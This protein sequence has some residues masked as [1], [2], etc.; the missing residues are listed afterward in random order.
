MRA[1]VFPG[2]E[3]GKR[4]GL[5]PDIAFRTVAEDAEQQLVSGTAG[6]NQQTR[7]VDLVGGIGND[8]MHG[9]GGSDIFTFGENWGKDT[10]EQLASGDVTL[11]LSPGRKTI[12]TGRLSLI[13]M[14]TTPWP[15]P[16]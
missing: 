1:S 6:K 3:I 5:D 15:S 14:E 7:L 11:W 2:G 16:A 10:V 4:A 8:R 12:G 13:R 9:G